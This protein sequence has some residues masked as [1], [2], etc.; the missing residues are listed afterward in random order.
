MPADHKPN[1]TGVWQL[2]ATKS[3]M[4]GRSFTRII[5]KIDHWDSRASCWR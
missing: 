1:F 3:H 4:L 2:D 5:A